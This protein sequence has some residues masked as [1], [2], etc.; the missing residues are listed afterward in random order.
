VK[1]WREDDELRERR[2]LDDC[3]DDRPSTLELFLSAIAIVA[4]LW[5][6]WVVVSAWLFR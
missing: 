3:P 6:L 5:A 1:G 4:S 2:G